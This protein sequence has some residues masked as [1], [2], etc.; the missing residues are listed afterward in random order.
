MEMQEIKSA[1]DFYDAIY[2]RFP[3]STNIPA[4][5]ASD[6]TFGTFNTSAAMIGITN[7]SGYQANNSEIMAILMDM[8]NYPDGRPTP[9]PGHSRNPQGTSILN[10]RMAQDTNSWGV[11]PDGVYRDPWG[12]PYI[13]TV[14]LNRDGKSRD[15]FYRLASVSETDGNALTGLLGLARPRAGPYAT[16]GERDSFEAKA[17]FMVWSLGPDGKADRTRKANEG[18]NKDNVLSWR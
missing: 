13:I 8:T 9:N 11:G 18:A 2:N 4:T 7:A 15:A 16:Q 1:I 5:A 6:F 12:N 14:D 3:I 17:E 10:P